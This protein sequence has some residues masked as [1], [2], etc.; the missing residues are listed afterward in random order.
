[1]RTWS[2]PHASDSPHPNPS[3]RSFSTTH[4]SNGASA[5][6]PA[7]AMSR[8]P[9]SGAP[10]PG[11][12]PPE[13][14]GAWPPLTISVRPP[15]PATPRLPPEPPRPPE[16]ALPPGVEPPRA[17]PSDPPLTAAPEPPDAGSLELLV[18]PSPQLA[19]SVAPNRT[20]ES[21]QDVRISPRASLSD[22][23][24][25]G[26]GGLFPGGRRSLLPRSVTLPPMWPGLP[27]GPSRSRGA[28][29]WLGP[30][31]WSGCRDRHGKGLADVRH[32]RKR[33]DTST[34]QGCP[35]RRQSQR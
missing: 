23:S 6:P 9:P 32:A 35:R 2:A 22:G 15:V 34:P 33:T 17:S 13:A 24:P 8:P 26:N 27:V 10:P 1:M 4:S 7:P 14:V 20:I 30:R 12:E 21:R 28:R 18:E 16:P 5:P 19:S 11:A 3:T 31:L 25:V 29:V